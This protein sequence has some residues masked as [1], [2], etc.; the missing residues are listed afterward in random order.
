MLCVVLGQ[1]VGLSL[2]VGEDACAADCE[3]D[4]QGKNCPPICP[5]CACSV[6][7][8]PTVPPLTTG[9]LPPASVTTMSAIAAVDTVPPSPE[10]REILHVPIAV[11]A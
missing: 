11:L 7:S 2:F 5:T 3:D 8:A 6:R 10:P 4:V 9:L 1:A